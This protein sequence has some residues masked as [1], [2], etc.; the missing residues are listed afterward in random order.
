MVPIFKKLG[1][2]VEIEDAV[3]FALSHKPLSQFYK[4]AT[5]V[6]REKKILSTHD[7]VIKPSRRFYNITILT[8]K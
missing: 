4:K 5:V 3:L 6:I 8:I 1:S 2:W 7:P